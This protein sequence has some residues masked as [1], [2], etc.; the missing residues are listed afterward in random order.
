MNPI[1]KIFIEEQKFSLTDATR[2]MDDANLRLKFINDDI[3]K[4]GG[5]VTPEQRAE[6]AELQKQLA[7]MASKIPQRIGNKGIIES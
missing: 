1:Y 3:R 6:R 7:E 2:S 4:A 5:F